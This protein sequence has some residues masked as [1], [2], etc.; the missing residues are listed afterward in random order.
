MGVVSTTIF[1]FFS[2]ILFHG[3]GSPEAQIQYIIDDTVKTVK[4]I[5]KTIL[6]SSNE[7]YE[8]HQ[9]FAI[10]FKN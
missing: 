3:C 7:A 9:C 5:Q 1:A 6:H 2:C 10:K 4:E 8:I